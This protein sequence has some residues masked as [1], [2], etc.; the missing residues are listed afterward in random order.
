MNKKALRLPRLLD[1]AVNDQG[2]R[3]T[4]RVTVPRGRSPLDLRAAE[5]WS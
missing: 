3:E 1:A 5:S 2:R 4:L